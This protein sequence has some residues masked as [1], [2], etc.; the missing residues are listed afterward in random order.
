MVVQVKLSLME[1]F[2]GL[3]IL[4]ISV[5]GWIY[6]PLGFF[7]ITSRSLI[8]QGNKYCYA[9]LK[10]SIA[11]ALFRCQSSFSTKLWVR[12]VSHLSGVD[13]PAALILPFHLCLQ[14]GPGFVTR[15]YY[16]NLTLMSCVYEGWY[17]SKLPHV[18]AENSEKCRSRRRLS[19]CEQ[20]GLKPSCGLLTARPHGPIDER[21]CWTL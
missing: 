7:R 10:H 8:K 2:K 6:K 5:T 1:L 18:K 14:K 11:A 21:A 3:D 19:S 16:S 17:Q 12:L 4:Y 20:N 9:A 15:G 13:L